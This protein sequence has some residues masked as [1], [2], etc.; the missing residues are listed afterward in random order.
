MSR[1]LIAFVVGLIGQ[2]VIRD[3]CAAELTYQKIA[4]PKR[5]NVVY[6]LSDDHRYD[7]MGFTGKYPWLKTPV[8]DRMAKEGM[9]L[10]NAFVTTSLCSPSRASIITGQYAHHHGIVDNNT[11]FKKGSVFFPQYLQKVGYQTAF[12]GKW[13]MG[14][15]SDAPRPGFDRWVSFRGQG[16][17]NPRGNS[18]KLNVDGRTVAQKG[19]ITD[20]LT[21]YAIDWLG[22]LDKK[23]P[24][25]MYLSHKAVHGYFEPAS[26]H[27]NLYSDIKIKYPK[28]YA[29]T[30]KNYYLKPKWVRDQ[31]NSWHGV[32]FAY[33]RT[34][35]VREYFR[36]YCR[37]LKGVDESIGRVI[38]W[39][40]DN[41]VADNTIVIY[42][43]DNGFLFGEHG[44]IDKRNAYEESMRVPMLAWSPK[45]I[46][47]GTVLK[48]VV[49][50]IDVGPTVLEVAGVKTLDQM[51]GK[52]FLGLLDET[53]QPDDWR[54][55]LLYEY[56]WEYNYPQ[57]PTTFALRGERYKFIQYHGIWDTDELYDLQDDPLEQRNLVWIKE[58]QKLVSSMRR[59]LHALLEAD[60]AAR[61]PFS[62]KRS[63]GQSLRVK[64]GKPAAEFPEPL[65]VERK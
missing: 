59:E 35:D 55:R 43:G 2:F 25:F 8:M 6:I 49:A 20:E 5:M 30:P 39:L 12:I 38:A 47:A 16:S 62:L 17:Y 42:M 65:R 50:N 19:Y 57:T 51:D 24:F 14:G 4:D 18:T 40:E 52:S 15:A 9:H 32:D 54:K 60:D 53:T 64:S 3:V 34:I 1:Y 46:K 33:H 31:R 22:K 21:E 10:T 45:L 7:A 27:K 26:R 44:L 48:Q 11:G 37:A 28:T 58:H 29:D 63:H 23:R 13:H 61:V 41:G 36:D 56:Y